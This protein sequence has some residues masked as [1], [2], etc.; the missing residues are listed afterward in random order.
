MN[1]GADQA[2]Q[3]A[4]FAGA[5]QDQHAG[6]RAPNLGWPGERKSIV[7]Q[8]ETSEKRNQSRLRGLARVPRG[9]GPRASGRGLQGL[10]VVA[11]RPWAS[12]GCRSE[13]LVMACRGGGAWREAGTGYTPP[14]PPPPHPR[15]VTEKRRGNHPT[16][17][18][19]ADL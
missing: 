9:L 3:D 11:F 19:S 14:A 8:A 18:R 4:R 16:R 5:C 1:L 12:F 17:P 10:G 2:V 15:F 6:R 13:K 7:Q